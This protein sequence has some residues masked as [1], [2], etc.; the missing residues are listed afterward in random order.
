M[1]PRKASVGRGKACVRGPWASLGTLQGLCHCRV[2]LRGWGDV[3]R[4]T[5]RAVGRA[6]HLVAGVR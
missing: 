5:V 2:S 1:S 3:S 4:R 6:A